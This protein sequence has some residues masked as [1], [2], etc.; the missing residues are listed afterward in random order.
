M[1][2]ADALAAGRSWV[3][4]HGPT[5]PGFRGAFFSGSVAV[6]P[7]T[8]EHPPWSDVDVMVVLADE[9]VPPKPGKIRHRGALLDVTYLPWSLVA[10][11]GTVATSYHLAHCFA[12]DQVILDP[13]GHLRLLHATI[14]PSF[15]DPA[16]VRLR[17]EN[18]ITTLE[19]RLAA[20][21]PSRTW[22]E[23]VAA[24]MFPASLPAH[25]ALVAACRNP[26]V[27]LRCLAAREVL[28][29]C[30]LDALYERLLAV[31]G[32]AACR[33]ETVRRHLDRL[34]TVFDEAVA[35]ARTPFF[36]TGDITAAAR[37][38][39]IDGSRRLVDGGDH[40]EAVFWIIATFARCLQIL[41]ADAPVSV[42]RSGAAAF[43][44]A[45]EDL[46]GLRGPDDLRARADAV[47][48]LLPELR[49]A[50]ATITA[51]GREPD[52]RPRYSSP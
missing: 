25:V 14:A 12:R 10:D 45:V 42:R 43:R 8:A 5:T 44:A 32:C 48:A 29:A 22:H 30:D 4:A 47:L 2:V 37:P 21:D 13:T 34:A 52:S 16:A 51:S 27:R 18:V 23:Q 49:R 39:A 11:V 1:L 36:F 38:I 9:P 50:A 41:T 46:L 33:P 3:L 7:A 6:R 28:G 20:L 24:W 19:S 40:R 35:V 15:A 31:L 17:C 26:T